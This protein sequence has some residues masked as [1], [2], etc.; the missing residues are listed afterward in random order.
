METQTN[1]EV[2]TH[3]LGI[4]FNHLS[5]LKGYIHFNFVVNLYILFIKD[6]NNIN[7]SNF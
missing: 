2:F 3:G 6:I 4:N 7:H 1:V 5:N